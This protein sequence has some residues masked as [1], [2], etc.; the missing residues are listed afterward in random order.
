MSRNNDVYGAGSFR[1]TVAPGSITQVGPFSGQL[2]QQLK[3]VAGGTLEI[4]GSTQT[5]ANFSATYALSSTFGGLYPVS[6]N[7]IFSWNNNGPLFL[8]ASGATVTV[9]IMLGR[10]QGF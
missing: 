8:Y 3:I 6:A 2:A 7:E 10:S 5:Q 9:A 4:G 1:V